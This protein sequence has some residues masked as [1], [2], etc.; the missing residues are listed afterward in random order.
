MKQYFQAQGFEDSLNTRGSSNHADHGD[1]M[2]GR[3]AENSVHLNQSRRG[4]NLAFFRTCRESSSNE[5][6]T[7]G[8]VLPA[9]VRMPGLAKA[10][11]RRF[12]LHREPLLL[13]V[14]QGHQHNDTKPADSVPHNDTPYMI[15]TC[16][17]SK[18]PRPSDM[19]TKP[20]ASA[21][22]TVIAALT[23]AIRM[24]QRFAKVYKS[25][26]GTGDWTSRT[27][28][29]W[30]PGVVKSRSSCA[31]PAVRIDG[32]DPYTFEAYESRTGQAAGRESF[33]QIAAGTG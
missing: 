5:R 20:A 3:P 19:N 27:S 18:T 12:P 13:G 11:R 22:S 16:A 9:N 31:N 14:G 30:P 32:I 8:I 28:W 2:M 24:N 17:T 33:E 6:I 26:Y 15:F 7:C 21:G 23:I 4:S 1:S 10:R 25:S 29:I